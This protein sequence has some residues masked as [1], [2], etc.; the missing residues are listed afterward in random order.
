MISLHKLPALIVAALLTLIPPAIQASDNLRAIAETYARNQ[1]RGLPGEVSVQIG[2]LDSSTQLPA[3]QNLQAYTPHGGRLWGKTFVGIRCLGPQTWEVLIPA[4][5]SVYS[6][7]VV[8]ARAL[9]GGQALQASDFALLRGD[10]SSLPAGVI[11]DR[12]AVIGKTL[13]NG[14]GP[15][16]PLRHD[17]LLAPLLIRS[18]QTVKLISR[19]SGFTVSGEGRAINNA[20]E[21]QVAQVRVPSGQTITGIVQADGSVE[22][23]R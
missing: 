7:Y 19:G 22:V 15:G 20:A 6:N 21:G 5:I 13:K 14:L 12:N 3:C 11:T 18:G 23:G 1:T 10:L 16:Q 9:A 17:Q 4:Q 2:H 8:S